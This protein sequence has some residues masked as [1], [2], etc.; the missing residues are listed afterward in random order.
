MATYTT[1][2]RTQRAA[3]NFWA[4]WI[5]ILLIVAGLA[6]SYVPGA[7]V[8][9]NDAG[10][11]LNGVWERT[12]LVDGMKAPTLADTGVNRSIAWAAGINARVAAGVR[13]GDDVTGNSERL[14]FGIQ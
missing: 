7:I 3:F 14:M 13:P 6:L 9:G 10:G 2:I 4:L 11:D 1:V 12:Y 5:G 8:R